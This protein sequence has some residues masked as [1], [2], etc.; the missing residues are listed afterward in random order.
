LAYL[1]CDINPP[2][3]EAM[4]I[5]PEKGLKE[6]VDRAAQEFSEDAL[7]SPEETLLVFNAMNRA[8]QRILRYQEEHKSPT[9]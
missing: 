8:L 3:G 7:A 6:V 5:E 4:Y 2:K 9:K 1:L